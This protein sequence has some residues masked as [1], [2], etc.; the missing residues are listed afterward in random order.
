MHDPAANIAPTKINNKYCPPNALLRIVAAQPPQNIDITNPLR[1][2]VR[3]PVIAPAI[4][5]DTKSLFIIPKTIATIITPIGK[6]NQLRFKNKQINPMIKATIVA[7]IASIIV[8]PNSL[9]II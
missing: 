3:N 4:P 8:P 9:D 7:T 5:A 2:A 6:L 1:N